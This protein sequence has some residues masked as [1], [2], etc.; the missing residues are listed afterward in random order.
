M[1]QSKLDE[2]SKFTKDTGNASSINDTLFTTTVFGIGDYYVYRSYIVK[3]ERTT[4]GKSS[5]TNQQCPKNGFCIAFF[6]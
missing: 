6:C 5:F 4:C 3:K 1:S 2:Y